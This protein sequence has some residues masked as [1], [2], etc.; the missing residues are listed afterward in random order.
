[1]KS[2]LRLAVLSCV[3]VKVVATRGGRQ[4]IPEIVTE[5]RSMTLQFAPT[6]A[7]AG[8][9]GAHGSHYSTK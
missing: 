5:V 1:M 2:L 3:A 7:Y 4:D 9:T 6:V 8:P